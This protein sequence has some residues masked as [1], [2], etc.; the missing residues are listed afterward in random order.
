V[1]RHAQV[2]RERILIAAEA[3]FGAQGAHGS[4]EEVAR[5]AEVGIATVFRHFPTKDALIEAALE[6]H[7]LQLERRA[8][9]LA[10]HLDS[11]EALD[12]L[13]VTL[14]GTGASKITMASLIAQR[15]DFP[16]G[17]RA[18]AD[19]LRASVDGVL[20]HAKAAGAVDA[21]VTVD[22]LYFL[23]RALAQASA[24]QPPDPETVHRAI[25]IIMRGLRAFTP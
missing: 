21:S 20:A 7:F 24:T 5:R 16:A 23:I 3:V 9:A 11:L 6:R 4:T 12:E 22:E 2:N 14:V 1:R 15:G 13:I 17:V 19:A 10:V 18:A 25:A 8:T